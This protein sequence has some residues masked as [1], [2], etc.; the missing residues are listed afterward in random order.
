MRGYVVIAVIS[1]LLSG[2]A[3]E[4]GGA[5][6]PDSDIP[7][8]QASDT[9][10]PREVPRS[11]SFLITHL[12]VQRGPDQGG[13]VI[14]LDLDGRVSAGDAMASDC[15]D[16]HADRESPLGVTG[17]D[18]QLV[19]ALVPMLLEFTPSLDL[20]QGL[21]APIVLGERLH[22]IRVT[23]LDALDDDPEVR[24]EVLTVERPGCFGGVCAPG[25][26]HAGDTF[27][28]RRM[29]LARDVPGAIV[30]GRLRFA[31]PRFVWVSETLWLDLTDVIVEVA[32]GEDDLVG[33]IA[34]AFTIDAIFDIADTLMPTIMPPDHSMQRALFERSTD[35]S[36]SS[37]DPSVCGAFSSAMTVEATRVFV[38]QR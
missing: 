35:L 9:N 34:G 15:R 36:P 18:N 21:D 20:E 13:E 30:E 26:I 2:C 29:S 23:E 6:A 38:P 31:L 8:A 19:V 37:S 17:V 12:E 33:V 4:V 3:C 16:R 22:A 14:G 27:V 24:V 11:A 1:A 10:E 32:V 28:D 7:D 25:E 5:I